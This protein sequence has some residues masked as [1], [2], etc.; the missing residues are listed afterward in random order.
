VYVTRREKAKSKGKKQTNAQR[1]SHSQISE[2]SETSG[3]LNLGRT[4]NSFG[5]CS[6]R[7]AAKEARKL[8][9]TRSGLEIAKLNASVSGDRTVPG[10]RVR[11]T[12]RNE[13]INA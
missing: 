5:S 3:G 4:F 1:I 9:V 10:V 11:E 13:T 7:V 12:K 6:V 2:T 8:T